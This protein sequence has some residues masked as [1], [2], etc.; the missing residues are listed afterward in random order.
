MTISHN[1]TGYQQSSSNEQSFSRREDI[2][3]FIF[4]SL[5][6]IRSEEASSLEQEASQNGGDLEID[7]VEGIGIVGKLE[8]LLDRRIAGPEDLKPQQTISVERLTNLIQKSL[9]SPPKRGRSQ[10]AS[11]KARKR[12]S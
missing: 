10:Q 2:Q 12:L 9:Q 6:E 5:A 3:H 7:S 1:G 8:G 4:E 11:K